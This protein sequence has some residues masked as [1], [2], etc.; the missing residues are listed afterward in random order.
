ML[1]GRRYAAAKASRSPGVTAFSSVRVRVASP[2]MER[3]RVPVAPLPTMRQYA[4]ISAASSSSARAMPTRA[5][6]HSSSS[7]NPRLILRSV[8]VIPPF[9]W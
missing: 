1:T 5:A 7:A 6:R 2:S 8:M 9:C 4:A 3:A